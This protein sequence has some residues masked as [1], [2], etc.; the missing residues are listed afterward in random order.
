MDYTEELTAIGDT[1]IKQR[2]DYTDKLTAIRD[3]LA[4]QKDGW[5]TQK[6]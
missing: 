4:K 2:I 3:N 5:I 1:L 6:D